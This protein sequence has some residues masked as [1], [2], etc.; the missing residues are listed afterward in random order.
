MLQNSG[1]VQK[2][3]LYNFFIGLCNAICRLNKLVELLKTTIFVKINIKISTTSTRN[4]GWTT[5]KFS[6]YV[7]KY[8]G[9]SV[10]FT[11]INL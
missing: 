1:K 7:P 10:K 5:K 6:V 4:V 8:W 9:Q 2:H 3:E 11:I